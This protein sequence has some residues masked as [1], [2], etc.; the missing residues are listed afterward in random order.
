[1]LPREALDLLADSR[2]ESYGK[3]SGLQWLACICSLTLSAAPYGA[4]TWLRTRDKQRASNNK[5]AD[6][7]SRS[8]SPCE[9]RERRAQSAACL[10][11][12][13][14][15]NRGESSGPIST[16][17]YSKLGL[18]EVDPKAVA[19][20]IQSQVPAAGFGSPAEI[21][22]AVVFLISDESAFAVGSELRVG[23]GR[24]ESEKRPQLERRCHNFQRS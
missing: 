18:S 5:R 7:G 11:C 12:Q 14:A 3:L 10:L 20:S 4:E 15:Y 17:L 21:A 23:W 9:A 8:R 24:C 2:A 1:M 13:S 6:I 22:S 19:D 16:P